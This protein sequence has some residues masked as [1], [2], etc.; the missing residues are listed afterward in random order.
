MIVVTGGTGLVGSY[1]LIKLAEEKSKVRVLIRPGTRPEKVIDVWK[2]YLPDPDKFLQQFEWYVTDPANRAELYDALSGAAYIYHCA[3]KVSFDSRDKKEMWE[4]NVLFTRRL[5]DFCL[6]H[7]VKKLVYVSSV[8]A[9]GGGNEGLISESNGFPTQKKSIYSQTKT[10]GE[11]EVWRGIAEGL[12]AVIVNPTV[13]L[14]PGNWRQSSGRFFHTAYQGMKFY[15]HGSTGFVDNRDVG[16]ILVRLM[17]SPISGERFI[18]N[19]A[20]L[21]FREIFTKI[22]GA[23]GKN[24][25]SQVIPP[26]IAGLGWRMEWLRSRLTGTAARLTKE[27]VKSAFRIQQYSAEKIETMLNYTFRDIDD[28]IRDTAGSYIRQ[29]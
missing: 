4:T 28:T 1:L 16:E 20:N 27:N 24:P 22:A 14:G 23:L 26:F 8:A 10:Q 7:S 3:G 15:T 25:P 2:H 12:D 19:A 21:S 13:I 5:V 18:L 11:F 6:Q 29:L 9:V 17:H